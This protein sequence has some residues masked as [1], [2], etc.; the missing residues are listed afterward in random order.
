MSND[1]NLSIDE[2]KA[3]MWISNVENEIEMAESILRDISRDCYQNNV[4]E[5]DTILKGISDVAHTAEEVWG[6]V[7][8]AF[9]TVTGTLHGFINSLKDA[10]AKAQDVL[11]FAVDVFSK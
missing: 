5:T 7:I 11:D 2:A 6:D 4:H 10:V 8:S 3:D 1:L 9:E